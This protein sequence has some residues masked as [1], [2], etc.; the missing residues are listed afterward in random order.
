MVLRSAFGVGGMCPVSRCV[1]SLVT[2]GVDMWCRASCIDCWIVGALFLF[3]LGVEC[4]NGGALISRGAGVARSNG[5]T[6]G[7]PSSSILI[8]CDV[9]LVIRNGPIVFGR[10]FNRDLSAIRSAAVLAVGGRLT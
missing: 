4:S 3:A 9:L 10:S 6:F 7:I 1:L 5:T 8:V 2:S